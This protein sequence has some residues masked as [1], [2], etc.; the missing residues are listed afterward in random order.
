VGERDKAE[1]VGYIGYRGEAERK[2]KERKG[3]E[4]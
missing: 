2:R 4:R 3:D 1:T